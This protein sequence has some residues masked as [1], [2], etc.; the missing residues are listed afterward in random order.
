MRCCSGQFIFKIN[1]FLF[2][3]ISKLND[4]LY[5]FCVER[6]SGCI[7]IYN[8]S[9]LKKKLDD[10]IKIKSILWPKLKLRKIFFNLGLKL[11]WLA[12]ALFDIT[13]NFTAKYFS[14]VWNIFYYFFTKKR[15]CSKTKTKCNDYFVFPCLSFSLLSFIFFFL[16]PYRKWTG[17]TWR[18]LNS[19]Q[20]RERKSY[21]ACVQAC[22][23]HVSVLRLS[24]KKSCS[25]FLFYFIFF[26]FFFSESLLDLM[27][28]R[29]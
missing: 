15:C 20:G 8:K 29:I 3:K 16:H 6:Y 10:S 23:H 1:G 2:G 4:R 11:K 25:V 13:L 19:E 12:C 17:Q 21:F 14:T 27:Q 18:E 5:R 28:K 24:H 22:R 9:C 7:Y 26:F